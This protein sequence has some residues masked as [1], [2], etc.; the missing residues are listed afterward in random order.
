MTTAREIVA[1]AREESRDKSDL[2]VL[3]Y[4]AIAWP[5]EACGTALMDENLHDWQARAILAALTAAGFRIVGPGE[6]DHETV[7]RCAVAGDAWFAATKDAFAKKHGQN[8]IAKLRESFARR[9]L[10][11]EQS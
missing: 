2:G 4:Q 7:E 3:L 9:A 6:V 10:K 1:R 11:E 8:F 5:S